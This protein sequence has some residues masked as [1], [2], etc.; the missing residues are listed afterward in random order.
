MEQ[1]S[2]VIYT[3]LCH[4]LHRIPLAED[5]FNYEEFEKVKV[6]VRKAREKK[7]S[8]NTN[9]EQQYGTKWKKEGEQG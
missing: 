6:M 3:T 9:T 7:A 1:L 5:H 2:Y 4:E 8:V